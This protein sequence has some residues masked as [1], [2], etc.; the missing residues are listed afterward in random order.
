[1]ETISGYLILEP[2]IHPFPGKLVIESGKIAAILPLNEIENKTFIAPGFIDCHTHPL[3]NGLAILF[4]DLSSVNSVTESLDVIADTVRLNTDLPV[5]MVFN[6][7]PDR[8]KEHRYLYRRELDRITKNKPIFVYRVDGHSGIANSASLA[9]LTQKQQEGIELD[10]AGRPTGV[11]R[12]KAFEI[13]SVLLK[14]LLPP[15]V[16]RDAIDLTARQAAT[17]GVTTIAAMVG[18]PEMNDHE[19]QIILE[20]LASSI[21]RMVPFVQTWKPD[22]AF[23]LNLSR[24]G[25]C[26]LLDGSFGSHTAAISGEYCDALGF[27]GML[28]QNDDIII[29]F[30]RQSAEL[31]L[32]TA[33]H[34]IGDRAIAQLIQCHEKIAIDY[35]IKELRHRIEHAELLTP[36]LI[37][38]IAHLNLV[39]CVQ[40]S[41]EVIWG[42]PS[43]MYSQR[44]GPRWR[45]TNPL[46]SLLKAG[47]H[48]AGGSDAPITTLDPLAGIKAAMSLPNMEQRLSPVDA[49]ALFTKNA[50]YALKMEEQIGSL[51]PG[52]TADFVILNADPRTCQETTILG[53][54]LAGKAIYEFKQ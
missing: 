7:D 29:E 47:V 5:I 48:I 34:A 27:N 36:E 40:P 39:L 37:S 50:A 52:F 42:G 14:R 12:G 49:F 23:R 11:V 18:S 2:E 41:F 13:I 45:L 53:T 33:F 54:Y 15:K 32:Q 20:A 9:L 31:G 22:L 17:R 43:R 1:M 16:I 10:G 24:I 25:G 44:L 38:R 19:W 6:F 4:P 26:L 46:K 51:K 28:Y 30:L 8:I 35:K 21:I 3:E